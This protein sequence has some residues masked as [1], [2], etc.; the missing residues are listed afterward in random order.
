[1]K[2]DII[3][4]YEYLFSKL[5]GNVFFSVAE[6]SHNDKVIS[7]FLQSVD[8][9]GEENVWNFLC[10]GFFRYEG[11]KTV[12]GKN[13]VYSTWIFGENAIKEWKQKTPERWFRCSEWKIKNELENPVTNNTYRPTTGYLDSLRKR[14]K[15]L[16]TGILL[17]ISSELYSKESEECLTCKD[18]SICKNKEKYF[19]QE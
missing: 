17:C 4:M 9:I 3:K 14:F 1:M 15:K 18:L 8:E 6:K 13:T 5:T 2:K 11:K 19:A 12:Q 10:Y 16:D 7:N